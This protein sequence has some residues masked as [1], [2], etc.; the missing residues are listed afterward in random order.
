MPLNREKRRFLARNGN[1][2]KYMNDVYQRDFEKNR[3]FDYDNAWT[4]MLLA[5]AERYHLSAEELH[6][7]AVDTLEYVNGDAVP[8]ELAQRLLD[9]YGFD[10]YEKPSESKLEY[11]PKSDADKCEVCG[12]EL[13]FIDD[14]RYIC[15]RCGTTKVVW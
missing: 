7:I 13:T 4:S 9:E 15:Q 11:I 14:H 10:Y 3:A 5:V 1:L 6:S 8:S 2:E 12:A